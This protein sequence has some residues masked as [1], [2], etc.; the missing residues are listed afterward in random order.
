MRLKALRIP[1]LFGGSGLMLFSRT[2][3]GTQ[4]LRNAL[5][6]SN[7]CPSKPGLTSIDNLE[8]KKD[9]SQSH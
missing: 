4:V 5:L 7:Q 9:F 6:K 8:A 3:V 2:L 1:S